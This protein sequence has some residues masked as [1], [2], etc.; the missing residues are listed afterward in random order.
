MY[1]KINY[2]AFIYDSNLSFSI[3]EHRELERNKAN[4]IY[5]QE[6]QGPYHSPEK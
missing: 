2:I 3:I 4:Y 1:I 6:A 5:Q